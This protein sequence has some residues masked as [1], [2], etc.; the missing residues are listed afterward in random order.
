MPP[1]IEIIDGGLRKTTFPVMLT[2]IVPTLLLLLGLLTADGLAQSFPAPPP[3]PSAAPFVLPGGLTARRLQGLLQ[4]FVTAEYGRVFRHLG[5]ER[6][7]DHGHLLLVDGRPVAIL[8][9]TQETG[10]APAS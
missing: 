5:D 3:S 6:D 8:Y 4:G 10:Y 2:R 7:F 1:Q 9:H